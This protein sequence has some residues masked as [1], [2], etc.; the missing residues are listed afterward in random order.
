MTKWLHILVSAMA[1]TLFMMLYYT[2]TG[3]S[4]S[5]VNWGSYT[6][7]LLLILVIP[8]TMGTIRRERKNRHE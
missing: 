8:Q 6:V 7:I 2:V 5:E 1:I 4:L 3:T